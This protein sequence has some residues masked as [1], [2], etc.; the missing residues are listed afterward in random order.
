VNWA[1]VALAAPGCLL[2]A[3]SAVALMLAA[4]GHHPMWPHQPTNLAEAAGVRDEAEVA[5]LIEDGENPNVRYPIRPGLIFDVPTRLT[6]LEAAVA[7]DD[8]QMVTRLLDDD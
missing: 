7:A 2:A 5:R 8:A 3:A 4:F 6:P 1:A